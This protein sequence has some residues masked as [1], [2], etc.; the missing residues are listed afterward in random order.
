MVR[1]IWVIRRV[2]RWK[3]PAVIRTRMAPND[4]RCRG[5]GRGVRYTG[6][7]HDASYKLLFSHAEMVEDLLRGFVP[8][9]WVQALDFSTLE[10]LNAN[11]VPDDLGHRHGEIVLE[12]RC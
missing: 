3:L 10:K 6:S 12:V 8:H 2:S 9:A 7:M 11:D 1:P 5:V 4:G